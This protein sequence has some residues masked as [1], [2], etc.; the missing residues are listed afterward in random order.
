MALTGSGGEA[1]LATRRRRC[2][3][4]RFVEFGF[5][6]VTVVIAPSIQRY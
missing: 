3:E 5:D 2:G 6:P 1:T 4:G